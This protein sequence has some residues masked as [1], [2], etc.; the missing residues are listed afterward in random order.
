ML[1]QP[2]AE[3]R[4]YRGGHRGEAR[5]GSDRLAASC[6]V[7]IRA[8][9]RKAAGDEK[10]SS[11]ALKAAGDHQLLDVGGES[12]RYRSSRKDSDADEKCGA[13]SEHVAERAANQNQSTEE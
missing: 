9:D 6:F 5:P 10:C 3:N 1:D 7:K 11:D 2:A 8:D 12:A 4:P 13:A